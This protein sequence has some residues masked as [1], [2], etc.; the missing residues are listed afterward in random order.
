MVVFGFAFAV[1]FALIDRRSCGRPR[2]I[3]VAAAVVLPFGLFPP[4]SE[5]YREVLNSRPYFFLL[6]WHWY[7]WLGIFAPLTLLWG[8]RAL[9][10][11]HGL[12]RLRRMC[13]ALIVYGLIF[14]G[15]ALVITIPRQFANLAELQPM[16]ALQLLYILL[17][18][19]AGGFLAQFV[20]K[21]KVWRW[22][23]LFVPLCLGMWFAQRQTF[24][25]TSHVEWA[26]AKPHNAWV[27]GFLW[28]RNNTPKDALFAL[29]PEYMALLGEDEHGFRAIAERSRLA[30]EVKDS[31][32]VT[33]FPAL[34]ETWR[35][36]VN[37]ETSWQ[38]FQ[39][40]DFQRLKRQFGVNWVVVQQS[41]EAGLRCPYTNAAIAVCRVE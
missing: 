7:E 1:I 19:F 4:V 13:S 18:V 5:A 28:I 32:A 26:G 35:E 6:R 2:Q 14:F 29:D 21:D 41:R 31:G 24:P 27:E 38:N 10:R 17:F 25:D 3:A 9:A 34:A 8:F 33:M 20:L 23:A 11:Q 16:R 37:A 36:Q 22:A 30:D 39:V 40:A 12:L 15:V